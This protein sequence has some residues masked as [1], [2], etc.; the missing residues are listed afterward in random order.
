MDTNPF[1]IISKE[2][3]PKDSKLVF[4]DRIKPLLPNVDDTAELVKST[5]VALVANQAT[6]RSKW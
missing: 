3:E 5:K 2:K 4:E 6:R 1:T